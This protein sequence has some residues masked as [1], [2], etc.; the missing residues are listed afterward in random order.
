MVYDNINLQII[1]V[2][3]E[4]NLIWAQK[5]EVTGVARLV[6]V[7]GDP[8][9]WVQNRTATTKYITSPKDNWKF[10]ALDFDFRRKALYWSEAGNKKIQGN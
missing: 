5:D 1:S 6:G 3:H 8:I 9:F 10:K 4:R 7:T 2:T